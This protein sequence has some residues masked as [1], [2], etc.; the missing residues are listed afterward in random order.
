MTRGQ[1]IRAAEHKRGSYN[2]IFEIPQICGNY[3]VSTSLR[4]TV[5]IINQMTDVADSG[6][7]TKL[8]SP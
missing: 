3:Y 1:Q 5:E 8:Y 6:Q 4:A 7:K 2:V